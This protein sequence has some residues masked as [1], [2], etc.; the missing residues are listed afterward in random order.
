MR[1]HALLLAM[2]ATATMT[3]LSAR[4]LAEVD[5][6]HAGE[7]PA[8]APEQAAAAEPVAEPEPV[9]I[10][11]QAHGRTVCLAGDHYGISADSARTAFGIVCDSLRRAGAPVAGIAA[12]QSEGL[13]AYRMELQRLD[14]TVILRVTY[15]NPVGIPR[16]SRSLTLSNLDELLVGADRIATALVSGKSVEETATVASLVGTEVRDYKKK[17]GETFWGAGLYGLA[18]PA[19][20]VYAAAG[21]EIPVFYETPSMAVGGSIRFSATGGPDSEEQRATFGAVSLGGR[22]FFG[23]GDITPYL[24]GGVAFGWIDLMEET[25]S[26]H[27]SGS[28]NGFGAFAE[29]G[30]EMLRL[31][32]SRFLVGARVDVPF[33]FAKQT[34]YSSSYSGSGGYSTTK[35]TSRRYAIP[36][37]LNVTFML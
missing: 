26:D 28:G 24:G 33:F 3:S 18:V 9:A 5:A 20:G 17:S 25:G 13:A 4:A 15:E 8:L 37:S 16:D 7:L 23:E 12:S 10:S 11:A 1:K 30:V 32:K 27:F 2:T 35:D 6:D 29:G 19:V 36:V 34:T 22:G 21:I 14:K 31:H